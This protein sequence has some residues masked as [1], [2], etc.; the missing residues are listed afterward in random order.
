MKK[1][2]A[3]K[4]L[5]RLVSQSAKCRAL[6]DNGIDISDYNDAFVDLVERGIAMLLCKNVSEYE[7]ILDDILWFLYDDVE[8]VIKVK[9]VKVDVSTPEK[10]INWIVDFYK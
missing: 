4:A 7:R 8:K 6:K 3:I 5:E 2:Y 9:G 1:E 10:M